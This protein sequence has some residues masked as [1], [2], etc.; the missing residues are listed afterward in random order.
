[1]PD[2]FRPLSNNVAVENFLKNTLGVNYAKDP[3]LRRIISKIVDGELGVNTFNSNSQTLNKK[4]MR[5]AEYRDD[6]KRWELRNLIV[7]ELLSKKRLDNDEKIALGKGGALPKSNV[8]AGKQSFIIIGLP[9]SGK[10][11]IA[12]Q[13]AED[14]GAIVID[15]DYAKRKL[16]EYDSHLY[17]A[18]IV[19]NESGCITTGFPAHYNPNGFKSLYEECIDKDYNIIIPKIGQNP[20]SIIEL[21]KALKDKKEYDVHLLLT[22]LSKRDATLRAVYRYAETGRYVPLGLIYDGY[23]NDPSLCY[24]YLRCKFE[25]L[26]ASF[27]VLLT[28]NR[29]PEY[30]DVKGNS[31]VLKYNFKDIILQLP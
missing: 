25:Q 9:A 8:K 6:E 12:S 21:A 31:P 4:D 19:H 15:S 26:F 2:S 29:P 3:K 17:S 28:L 27:G 5:D 22:S 13:I 10:S 23:G 18:S 14:Y 20:S 11:G 16:P 1:M 30:T 24:Y 7:K